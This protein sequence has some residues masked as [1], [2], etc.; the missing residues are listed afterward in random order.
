M[1]QI[2]RSSSVSYSLMEHLGEGLNSTVYKAVRFDPFHHLK[3]TVAL[4]VLKSKNL[5]DIWK[6]EFAS[7]EKVACKNCVRVFGFEW[8]SGRPALILEYVN[9]VSLRQLCLAAPISSPLAREILAQIQTGLISLRDQG[10]CHGD[11]SPNNVMIDE[12]GV[13]KLLDFG[14]ANTR[15]DHVQATQAFAAPEILAGARPDFISDLYSL[16]VLEEMLLQKK[17]K[18]LSEIREER[19][20]FEFTS[21]EMQRKKLGRLVRRAHDQNSKWKKMATRSLALSRAPKWPVIPVVVMLTIFFLAPSSQ[22]P[23][24]AIHLGLLK[25]RTQAWTEILLDGQKIGFAPQDLLVS[26][27]Q[28]HELSWV[29]AHNRGQRAIRMQPKQIQLIEDQDLK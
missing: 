22:S 5:V 6:N 26:A 18:R 20:P 27:D 8:V 4:K 23:I 12:N 19:A 14:W 2:L 15:T 28:K 1:K 25:I 16:G 7:L 9:G 11:L 10:L 29:T 13:I 17:S 24:E 3:Q 21:H